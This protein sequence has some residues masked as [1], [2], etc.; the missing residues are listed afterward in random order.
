MAPLHAS[1]QHAED[2]ISGASLHLRI[3]HR[4]YETEHLAKDLRKRFAGDD[5]DHE[6]WKLERDYQLKDVA[7]RLKEFMFD[8]SYAAA[9]QNV[10]AQAQRPSIGFIVAGYSGDGDLAEE[11]RI[12]I[13][14][15]GQCTGPTL[16]RQPTEVGLTW[17]GMP[18]PITRLV[19]GYSGMF[20]QVLVG[21]GLQQPQIDSI[22]KAAEALQLP[23]VS[24][25]MPIQDA[26]DLAAF[27][28]DLTI[29]S[30]R[31]LPGAP[32][33]GGPIEIAAITKHEGFKWVRRKHYFPAEL[34]PKTEE[35]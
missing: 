34:N 32:V 25:A 7:V 14:G 30:S 18:E 23:F 29:N 10:P 12:D 11:Y 2:T 22:M 6:D 24:P 8:E 33:V 16:L 9:F 27:L 35:E 1:A 15:N 20:A 4:I 3:R 21:I 13:A 31:F 26:I 28:V 5:K 19:K 17:S